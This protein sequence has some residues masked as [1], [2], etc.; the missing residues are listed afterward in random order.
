MISASCGYILL[1]NHFP[2]YDFLQT[3]WG[4]GVHRIW[5]A[6]VT[7]ISRLMTFYKLPAN[8][9]FPDSGVLELSIV[10]KSFCLGRKGAE[11][12]AFAQN[13]P[14]SGAPF[15]TGWIDVRGHLICPLHKYRFDMRNGYNVSGEGYRLKRFPLEQREDGLYIGLE[16]DS[17]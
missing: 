1:S 3:S 10:G 6:K 11:T 17:V 12:F 2:S 7:I 5:D 13:C 14:H 16:D 4:P 15:C 8:L 9:E